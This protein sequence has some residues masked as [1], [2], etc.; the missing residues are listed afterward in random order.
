M[1]RVYDMTDATSDYFLLNG[2]SFPYTLRDSIITVK[3]DEKI[4]MRIVNGQDEVLSLH[5][6]GHKATIT[7]YDG[8]K[9]PEASRITRDVYTLSSAQRIDLQLDTVNALIMQIVFLVV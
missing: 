2:H 3:S 6:H 4:K 5:T 8:V 7:H 9:Q 1:N